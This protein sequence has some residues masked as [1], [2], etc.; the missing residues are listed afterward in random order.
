MTKDQSIELKEQKLDAILG[1][2]NICTLYIHGTFTPSEKKLK[3][4]Y[5]F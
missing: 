3:V 4:I 5:I 1:L 2:E